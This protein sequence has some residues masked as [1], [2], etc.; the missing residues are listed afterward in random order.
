M[1][2]KRDDCHS[3]E[4]GLWLRE[5]P[6][7]DSSLGFIAT[8]IDYMWYSYKTGEWMLIEEKRH[9]SR[10]KQ[11]QRQMFSKINRACSTDSMYRGFHLI[12]FENTNVTDGRVWVDNQEVTRD[13]LIKFL[14]FEL[15]MA[16]GNDGNTLEEA[17]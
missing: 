10:V 8:N 4:F 1:T 6:E 5:Q 9:G 13:Q 14:R 12:T 3:T 16:T 7:I 11:W 15:R 2:R 17:A